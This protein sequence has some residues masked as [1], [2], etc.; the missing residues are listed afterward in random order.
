LAGWMGSNLGG[1]KARG[2]VV[3]R[4]VW[5]AVYLE[6]RRDGGLVGGKAV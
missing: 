1:R 3:V 4:A 6:G 2:L 5:K